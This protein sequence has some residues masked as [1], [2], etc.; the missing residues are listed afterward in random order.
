LAFWPVLVLGGE[1]A[2]AATVFGFTHRIQAISVLPVQLGIG[3]V[4]Q[5]YGQGLALVLAV[6]CSLS[7]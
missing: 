6:F 4:A 7:V 2:H 5:E 1:A 3:Q